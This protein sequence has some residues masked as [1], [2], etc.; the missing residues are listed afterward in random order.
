MGDT[1]GSPTIHTQLQRI[2]KQARDYPE[3][4]FNNLYHLINEEMLRE[5][6]KRTRKN[7]ALGVDNVTAEQYA[8][9]LDSNL[10]NLCERL[11]SHRYKARP[12]KRVWIKKEGGKKRPLGMPTLE[13]KI[14]QRACEMLLASIYEEVFYSFSYGYRAGRNPHQALHEVRE[15]CRRKRINWIVDIDISGFFD[16]IAHKH[17]QEFIKRKV[18]DGGIRRL[19]GKWLK[20]GVMEGGILSYSEAGTPQGGVISPLLSNIFLHYI[21]DEWFVEVVKPRMRGHC[22]EVRFADDIVMGF[23]HEEDAIRVMASLKQRFAKY[24]LS[25]NAEKTKQIK[26]GLPKRETKEKMETFDFLGF[27]HYWTKSRLGFWVIKRKTASKRLSR[28][29]KQVWEW[30]RENRHD[31]LQD[32]SKMLNLKLRGY[33]QY[34]GIRSNYKSLEVIYEEVRRAWK[35]WLRRRSHKGGLNWEKFTSKILEIFPLIKPRIT[36]DI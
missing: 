29:V 13:D 32:Q 23:E 22:F 28:F 3:M 7:A 25:V 16:N 21:L 1:Q 18:N 15:Q 24:G 34:Y 6:F 4:V 10:S 9:E 19:I 35:Y 8:E 31:S 12:V 17:L 27:T 2:A 14:T 11:K 36:H 26:F 33:Y 30:C 20:A 5:A